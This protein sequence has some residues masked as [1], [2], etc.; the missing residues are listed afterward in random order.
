VKCASEDVKL[1]AR[2]A[3]TLISHLNSAK[4]SHR[5]LSEV[6]AAAVTYLRKHAGALLFRLRSLATEV[7]ISEQRRIAEQRRKRRP[8]KRRA[9]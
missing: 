1:A 5:P 9:A 8:P 6:E 3:K 4:D 7:F 2:A